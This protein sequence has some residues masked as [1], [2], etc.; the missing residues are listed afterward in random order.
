[1]ARFSRSKAA[2]LVYLSHEGGRPSGDYESFSDAYEALK[3]REEGDQEQGRILL[4]R[5]AKRLISWRF[6]AFRA[7]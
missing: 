1:M 2:A 4:R 6:M 7:F 3:N 5:M